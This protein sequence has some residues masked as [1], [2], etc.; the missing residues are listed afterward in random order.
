MLYI[1]KN[2]TK[3]SRRKDI[4]S[5]IQTIIDQRYLYIMSLPLV[6]WCIIFK[7]LPIWGWT[8]AFQRFQPGKSFFNQQWVGLANFFELFTDKRFYMVLRNTFAMGILGLSF[9]FMA[10]IAFALLINEIRGTAFKRSI[11]TISYLPHFVSW[12]VVASIVTK[13]LSSTGI[14]N[15]I[16][17]NL[18][19]TDKAV[20]FTANPDLFWWI[21]TVSDVWKEMGWN[22][23]IFIS[24][25]VSI[26]PELY[27]AAIADGAGRFRRIWHVTLPGIRS[28]VII[29]LMMSIGWL[30]QIGFEKQMLLGNPMVKDMSEVLDLYVLKYA[31]KVGRYSFGTA[32][33]VF[34]S[35][36]SIILLIFANRLA[37]AAG[38][39]GI[40]YK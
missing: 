28:T 21:V 14:V 27:E 19:V 39:E 35:A 13:L 29:V 33:G 2:K 11:Q 17:I 38:E 10:S 25:V 12:I 7:Y 1:E 40:F 3:L 18:H 9:G 20:Q 16:L 26:N 30:I 32:I 24:V 5:I 23:I 31:L 15:M 22:S 34:K 8:M 4:K 37:K 6:I 36:V